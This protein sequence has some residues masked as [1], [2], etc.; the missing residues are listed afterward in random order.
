VAAA[1]AGGCPRAKSWSLKSRTGEPASARIHW[2]EDLGEAATVRGKWRGGRGGDGDRELA[3]R[4]RRR[5]LEGG[6]D[7]EE[8]A[9][10]NSPKFEGGEGVPEQWRM[11]FKMPL[12]I[13]F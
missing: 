7:D 1:R 5:R 8:I 2:V 11:G 6:G 13:I 10:E 4:G 3:R 9:E 12:R